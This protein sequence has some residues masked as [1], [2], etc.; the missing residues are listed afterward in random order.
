MILERDITMTKNVL[1]S[2][3]LL[4]VPLFGGLCSGAIDNPKLIKLPLGLG[5]QRLE[6]TPV[7]YQGRPLLIE[8]SR[9]SNEKHGNTAVDMYVV[10]LTTSEIISRFGSTFAF[11]CAFVRGT[12]PS[13]IFR[14]MRNQS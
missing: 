4:M 9:L 12:G 7:I 11:N 14:T 5:P 13:G 10:D 3:L 1:T 2:A 8:N 6:N